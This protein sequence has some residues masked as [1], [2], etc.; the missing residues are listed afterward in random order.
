MISLRLRAILDQMRAE[1]G[2]LFIRPRLGSGVVSA[3]AA[4]AR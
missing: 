3:V 1:T 2:F 4:R